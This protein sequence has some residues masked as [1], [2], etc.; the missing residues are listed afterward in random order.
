ML[1]TDVAAAL[2]ELQQHANSEAQDLC[3]IERLTGL[4]ALDQVTGQAAEEWG[5]VAARVPC[6]VRRGGAQPSGAM[7]AGGDL[8]AA[9][10]ILRVP[11]S[12][13]DVRQGDRITI[14]ESRDAAL[15]GCRFHVNWAP[16][17]THMVWRRLQVT[18]VV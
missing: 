6:S 1:G 4:R 3:I 16:K 7:P 8:A 11:T 18:E 15:I 14:T 12:V 13:T 17:G 5:V 2:P 9:Q 10:S